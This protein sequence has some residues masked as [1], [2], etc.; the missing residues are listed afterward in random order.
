MLLTVDWKDIG[1]GC[2]SLF[3]TIA[4]LGC[5]AAKD[6]DNAV[7]IGGIASTAIG[8][9][10]SAYSAGTMIRKRTSSAKVHNN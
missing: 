1:S 10:S 3:G 4:G 5:M 9:V 6:N 7:Y 8:V 2:F